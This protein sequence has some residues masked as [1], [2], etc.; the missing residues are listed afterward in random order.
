M[1]QRVLCVDHLLAYD[2]LHDVDRSPFAPVQPRMAD[3]YHDVPEYSSE[4]ILRA[5][6]G[7]S[8]AEAG[9]D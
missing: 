9:M 1:L 7:A 5:P 4:L 6:V 2:V 8:L 3:D